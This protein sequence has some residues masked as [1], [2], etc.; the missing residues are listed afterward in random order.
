LCS[1]KLFAVANVIVKN[2]GT[3]VLINN[4]TPVSLR[5]APLVSSLRSSVSFDFRSVQLRIAP[6]EAP[7]SVSLSLTPMRFLLATYLGPLF[8]LGD[9]ELAPAALFPA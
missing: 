8:I 3:T 5:G 9:S 6:G 2:L 4:E 1:Q 7:I